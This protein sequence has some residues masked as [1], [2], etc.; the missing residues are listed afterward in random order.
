MDHEQHVWE[1]GT[2][3]HPVDVVVSRGLGSV[4]ITALGAV[5]LHHRLSR[6]IRQTYVCTHRQIY[7]YCPNFKRIES[8]FVAVPSL[9]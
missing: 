9:N 1:P 5:D 4:D 8:K 7:M 6:H 2:K 3:I